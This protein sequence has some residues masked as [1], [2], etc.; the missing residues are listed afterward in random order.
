[1]ISNMTNIFV[2][3]M[4]YEMCFNNISQVGKRKHQEE[5]LEYGLIDKAT[6]AHVDQNMTVKGRTLCPSLDQIL[7]FKQVMAYALLSDQGC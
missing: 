6:K 3:L 7:S 5:S 2:V 4:L 1:M